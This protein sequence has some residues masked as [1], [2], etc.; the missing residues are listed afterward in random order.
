M[1]LLDHKKLVNCK[2]SFRDK[3]RI[4]IFLRRRLQRLAFHFSGG[5]GAIDLHGQKTPL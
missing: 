2:D 3:K 5:H 4:D 1:L